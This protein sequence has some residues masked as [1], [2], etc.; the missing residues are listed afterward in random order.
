MVGSYNIG[1][2]RIR[3]WV[4]LKGLYKGYGKGS[5]TRVL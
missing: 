1:A 4:P 5:I 3:I 2:L